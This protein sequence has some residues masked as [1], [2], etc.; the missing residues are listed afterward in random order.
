[1]PNNIIEFPGFTRLDIDPDKV[2]EAEKGK[3]QSVLILGIDHEGYTTYSSSSA[4]LG[5]L[6]LLVERFKLRML[7]G[8][9]DAD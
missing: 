5:S 3:L 7:S 6:L 1:M 2:L 4:N 9:F 8:D